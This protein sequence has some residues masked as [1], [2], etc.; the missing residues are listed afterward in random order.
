MNRC[1]HFQSYYPT[2]VEHGQVK[3][4]HDRAKGIVS[5][6]DYLQKNMDHLAIVSKQKVS[7]QL[8]CSVLTLCTWDT[9]VSSA[10]ENQ[11]SKSWKPAVI[12]Y[13]VEMS[14]DNECVCRKYGIKVVFRSGQTLHWT[15]TG[16][17]IC[18]LSVNNP[19]WCTASS[20]VVVRPASERQNRKRR[21]K[22]KNTR[23][24]VRGGLQRHQ[25]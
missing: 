5:T 2:C 7:C 17:R 9:D 20:E 19:M 14:E 24:P 22:R 13:V 25:P 1:L 4:L 21:Q 16:S 12:S 8:D 15:L 18:Y 3:C 23:M 11:E 10:E 6:L